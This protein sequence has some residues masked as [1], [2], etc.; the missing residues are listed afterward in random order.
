MIMM[1]QR[2]LTDCN[3]TRKDRIVIRQR[4]YLQVV[5]HQYALNDTIKFHSTVFVVSDLDLQQCLRHFFMTLICW[6]R[7]HQNAQCVTHDWDG[8]AQH[9]DAK[10]KIVLTL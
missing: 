1:Q 2:E 5:N 10:Q 7:L 3:V 9:K 8:S 6:R 4:P